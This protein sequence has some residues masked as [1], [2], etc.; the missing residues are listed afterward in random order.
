MSGR[1]SVEKSNELV[2]P[3]MVMEP[4]RTWFTV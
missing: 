1:L 4:E 3:V 2:A